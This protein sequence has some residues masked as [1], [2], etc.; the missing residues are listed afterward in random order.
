M[1]M[2]Q[3]RYVLA[4]ARTLNFTRAAEECNVSQPALT[5]A[6]KS[7]EGELSTPLFY[8]EGR[9]VMLSDFGRSVLPNMQQILQ[10]ADAARAIAENFRLLNKVPV[11]IGVLSTIGHVRLARFFARLQK[12]FPGVEIEVSEGSLDRLRTKL[13]DDDLDLAVVNPLDWPSDELR[14]IKLYQER[15]VVIMPPDH[16]LAQLDAIRLSDLSGEAYVDRLSC[17]MR[18]LVMSACKSEGVELYARFRSE[19]EDWIQ[20]MV[21]AHIGFAFM[22]EYSITLPELTQRPLTEPAVSRTVALASFPGRP[23]NPGAAAI[24]RAAQMFAWPG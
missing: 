4:A 19:R 15:Y 9:R 24:T 8:R 18:E 7:L 3:I 5:R 14:T 16:R 20:A 22:P 21:M 11:R 1:E 17:E 6:I 12:D 23:H 13:E 2:H 10:E